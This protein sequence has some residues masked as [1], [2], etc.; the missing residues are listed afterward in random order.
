VSGKRPEE[1]IEMSN[2]MFLP[3]YTR[4]TPREILRNIGSGFKPYF[5]GAGDGTRTRDLLI[6]KQPFSF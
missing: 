3:D 4:I 6:T 1:Y 2:E 5:T